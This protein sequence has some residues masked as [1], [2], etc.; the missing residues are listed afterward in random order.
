MRFKTCDLKLAKQC[1]DFNKIRKKQKPISHAMYVLSL[2]GRPLLKCFKTHLDYSSLSDFKWSVTK[3]LSRRHFIIRN[4][5][6]REKKR[7]LEIKQCLS[8]VQGSILS[9]F[10]DSIFCTK[11]CSKPNSKQRKATQKTFIQKMR[12]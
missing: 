2:N 6:F 12:T 9:T 10:Y 5:F 3:W 7:F 1:L 4:F 8:V 11:V